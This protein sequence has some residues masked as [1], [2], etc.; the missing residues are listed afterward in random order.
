MG[1]YRAAYSQLFPPK[2][3]FTEKDIPAGS[4]VG[5]VFLITGANQG[6]GFELVKL[7]YHS[8]A[9]I[10]LAG[11]SVERLNEA[12]EIITSISPAPEIPAVLKPL[13]LDLNDLAAVKTSATAFAAQESRLDVLWNNAGIGGAPIGTTTK[14]GIEG[15]IGVNCVGPLL[16]TQLLYPLLQAAA[17]SSAKGS[18]RVV[19]T[20]SPIVDMGA[21]KGGIDFKSIDSGKTMNSNRDY[22]CS[23]VGNWFLADEGA[24]RW[25]KDGIVSVVENP[26]NLNTSAYR[27]QSGFMMFFVKP[28]LSEPKFGGY[29]M[30][31][32]G[33]TGDVGLESNGA[34]IWPFGRKIRNVR[35]DIYQAIEEGKAS[36]FWDW[37][38]KKF[39]AY[40]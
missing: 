5:K 37:C 18:V 32:A 17:K 23:K 22:S 29:T 10:Y 30:L 4:Q 3:T 35:E 8:G 31:Y 12:I 25:G 33:F 28:I 1:L 21:P 2:P 26:G 14:Q 20:S 38:E 9:T 11:R 15:H 19:W 34:Y 6:I 39:E 24:K 36:E 40:V 7:L 13:L 16:F 27:Y